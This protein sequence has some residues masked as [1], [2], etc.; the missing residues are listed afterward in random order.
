MTIS[1]GKAQNLQNSPNCHLHP[2]HSSLP[3][4]PARK[5]LVP[6]IGLGNFPGL[7]LGVLSYFW[8]IEGTN[9]YGL[10]LTQYANM[11]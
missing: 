4:P 6:K 10:E 11:M 9:S 2:D 7:S 5:H 1:S 8:E 3:H